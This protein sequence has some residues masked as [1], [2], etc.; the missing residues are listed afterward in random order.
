MQMRILEK[1]VHVL[2]LE[3]E[4]ERSRIVVDLNSKVTVAHHGSSP[5]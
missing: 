5:V 3:L 2:E 4:L 1:K